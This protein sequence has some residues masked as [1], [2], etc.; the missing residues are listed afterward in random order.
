[1]QERFNDH[2]K[3]VELITDADKEGVS[4][5]VRSNGIEEDRA[6]G[7]VAVLKELRHLTWIREMA[8]TQSRHQKPVLQGLKS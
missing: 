6:L 7:F 4:I 8:S 1:M 3:M 2:D 5:H